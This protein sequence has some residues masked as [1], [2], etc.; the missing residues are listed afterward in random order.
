MCRGWPGAGAF[1]AA[2]LAR[3]CARDRARALARVRRVRGPRDRWQ[4]AL[5]HKSSPPHRPFTRLA[6]VLE[7]AAILIV[8]RINCTKLHIRQLRSNVPLQKILTKP[9]RVQLILCSL[10][11][12]GHRLHMKLQY[13]NSVINKTVTNLISLLE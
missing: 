6:R 3:A 7:G 9:A 8:P 4:G 12:E 1:T 13:T 10:R 2:T 5:P 11:R